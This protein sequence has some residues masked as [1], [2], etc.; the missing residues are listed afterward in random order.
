MDDC[1][2]YYIPNDFCIG[3]YPVLYTGQY[4]IFLTTQSNYTF[5]TSQ[6]MQ[7]FITLH[8]TNFVSEYNSYNIP[9]R[10]QSLFRQR[11]PC[12]LPLPH[13]WRIPISRSRKRTRQNKPTN[14]SPK[15][16]SS[17]GDLFHAKTTTFFS[18][19]L[20]PFVSPFPFLPQ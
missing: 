7:I 17:N 19:S 5:F 2:S 1:S 4:P 16:D 11:P 18:V 13:I 8:Q 14:I 12:V 3:Y 15:T 6:Y 9:H 10:Y 20:S